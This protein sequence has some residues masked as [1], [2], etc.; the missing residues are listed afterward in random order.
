MK[1]YKKV[2]YISI[3]AVFVLV[4]AGC[5]T[6]P[7]MQVKNQQKVPARFSSA[8]TDTVSS[9]TLPIA[10]FFSDPHLVRLIDTA[11]ARNQDVQSAIQKAEIAGA[12]FKMSRGALLPT[13]NAEANAGL[14][15][16]GDYTMNGVGN[17]D[18][19]LSPNISGRQRIPNPTPDY[20]LGFRSTWEIDLWG[21][22]RSRKK[23]AYVRFLASKNAYRLVT[24]TMVSQIAANYY[25]LLKLDN[26]LVIIRKNVALQ[27]DAVEL[28]R[29]QKA[30]G[31]ATELA[32]QQFR[33]Q[34]ARTES[35]EGE[36]M[37]HIVELK[38][39]ILFLQGKFE[40][41][42]ERDT[43][44]I[45]QKMPAVLKLGVPAKLLLNRPD[46]HT[47]ELELVAMNAD[48][49]AARAAFLPSLTLS[50]YVGLNAFR[51]SVLFNP[52]SLA[53]GVLGGLTAP[54]FNQNRLKASYKINVAEAKQ[55]LFA[56]QKTIINGF[57]E[58]ETSLN[59]MSN[60]RNVFDKKQVEVEALR[61]AL[62]VANDL[63]LVGRAT[64]L[65]VIT[66]QRN[67]LDA[68]LQLAEAKKNVY[69]NAINM[70][71]SL[72]GGWH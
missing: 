69:L 67:V 59:G 49:A 29:I 12:Y 45:A 71:R 53:Y 56:Y 6:M 51:S 48:I 38:N 33:A 72:G 5:A 14:E 26:E 4:A 34:L 44:I 52:G 15:K 42:V 16:F 22:L 24:T 40:G 47:A 63:F 39:N 21:K 60:Y 43:S 18:T 10:D 70:Y 41:K 54:I 57:L 1:I 30:G 37:Q 20:F 31:R 32:V 65:E 46:I 2:H 19:N 7:K 28:I 13:L 66:A 8:S 11:L 17:Y 58:V 62:G 50:P 61:S 3:L 25:E 55:S 36:V 68:E 9:A 27:K 35:L 64:Y 23:A